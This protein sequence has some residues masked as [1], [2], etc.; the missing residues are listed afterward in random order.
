MPSDPYKPTLEEAGGQSI[1]AF[2]TCGVPN[3]HF[4]LRAADL[5][6]F[7]LEVDGDGRQV[8]HREFVFVES[9]DKTGLSDS[10]FSN[11]EDFD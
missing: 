9:L 3:L 6:D 1:E 5:H 7:E 8:I 4:K 10:A 2:L 11:H